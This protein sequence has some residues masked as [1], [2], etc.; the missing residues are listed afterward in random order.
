VAGE[1]SVLLFVA[2]GGGDVQDSSDVRVRG[3]AGDKG[4][5]V[6]GVRSLGGEEGEGRAGRDADH[7]YFTFR[8]IRPVGD[9]A[10]HLGGLGDRFGGDPVLHQ[11][12][13]VR[14]DHEVPGPGEPFRQPPRLGQ[15]P[16]FGDRAVDEEHRRPRAL[17]RRP[18]D[19]GRVPGYG[20]VAKAWLAAHGLRRG[21]QYRGV[22]DG[23]DHDDRPRLRVDPRPEDQN[24]NEHRQQ[25][26]KDGEPAP[27]PELLLPTDPNPQSLS[28]RR[29]P[30]RR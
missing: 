4:D 20:P 14:Q 6:A 8:G 1:G 28:R 15:L 22:E 18:H 29:R 26:E 17:P 5:T 3:D 30:F 23:G 7:G 21:R 10:G 9:G 25:H 24:P 11:P 19:Q 12:R 13:K 27:A 2:A 16:A